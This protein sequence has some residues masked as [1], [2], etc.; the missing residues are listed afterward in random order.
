MRRSA[1]IALA[2]AGALLLWQSSVH[3]ATVPS[4]P[5]PA[6]V[7]PGT[8]WQ[9]QFGPAGG[10]PQQVVRDSSPLSVCL[11]PIVASTWACIEGPRGIAHSNWG[12]NGWQCTAITTQ[13]GVTSGPWGYGTV[14]QGYECSAG[15]GLIWAG[16]S[17]GINGYICVNQTAP[18]TCPPGSYALDSGGATCSQPNGS[19]PDVDVNAGPGC[20]APMTSKPVHIGTGNKVLEETDYSAASSSELGFKRSYNSQIRR[21]GVVLTAQWTHTFSRWVEAFGT[22]GAYLFRPD[23]AVHKAQLVD[24]TIT[25]DQ[26]RWQVIGISG[27]QL[28]RLFGTGGLP[29]GWLVFEPRR[30][31]I[32]QYDATGRLLSISHANGIRHT[33]TYSDGTAGTGGGLALDAAGAATTTPLP[34]GLLIRIVDSQGRS[35]RL[36]YNS[37][38]QLVRLT[39]PAGQFI[40]YAYDAAANLSS[41]TYPDGESRQYLYNE[42]TLT[43][44]ANLPNAITGLMDETGQRLGTYRYDGSGRVVESQ[45]WADAAQA[46]H[47]DRSSF[48]FTAAAST[49]TDGLDAQRTYGFTTINGRLLMTAQSQPAGAG[50]EASSRSLGYDGNGNVSTRTNFNGTR[51]CHAYDPSR[52]LETARI[53]GLGSPDTCPADIGAVA[54]GAGA[55]QRKTTTQWHPDWNL[56]ARRAEANR[57][58]TSV[59]NGQPDPTAA[60]AVASCAPASAVLPDGKPIAVLCKTVEQATAD[61][62]G[63]LG[64]GATPSGTPRTWSYTYNES[65]QVLT[66]RNPLNHL[67][68]YTYY[69]DT[70]AEHTQGDLQSVINAAGHA[71]QYARYDRSGRLQQ[72]T[73]VNGNVTDSTYTSRGWVKTVTV[74]PYGALPQPT[75]YDYD[76]AGLLKKATLPDGTAL[77]YSHDVAHRLVGIRDAAGNSVTYTLDSLGNRTGEELRDSSGTLARNITRVY[78]ALNRLK[79]ATGEAQ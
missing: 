39:D 64:F 43:G 42:S 65:G 3:A 48:T 36:D 60:G 6:S 21:R 12:Y 20:P 32:E 11:N 71:T 13:N 14:G 17:S 5:A 72:S 27:E 41:V 1:R 67:S 34:A 2:C 38:R 7:L 55:S 73:D 58:T 50:C 46:R 22:T 37:A 79:S 47:V 77:E 9:W 8:Y 33:L 28:I 68:T 29:I 78:D 16:G 56:V 10:C 35:L 54:I 59:Y 62:T 49:V 66:A 24:T 15:Y 4:I 52:N 57:I 74:T 40:R 51:N 18:P 23:G 19:G 26:Q 53:E 69:S 44:G 70:T 25:A 30:R 61:A 76:G 75:V 63:A 31:S 45:W